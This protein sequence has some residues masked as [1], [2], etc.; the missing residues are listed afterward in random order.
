MVH[1]ITLLHILLRFLK[2][3]SLP[4]R[5]AT[6]AFEGL[7]LGKN[8]LQIHNNEQQL[9]VK[10]CIVFVTPNSMR[11]IQHVLSLFS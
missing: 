1:C 3:R 2:K 4:C 6:V 9:A 11:F 7:K 8:L 5:F 10:Y